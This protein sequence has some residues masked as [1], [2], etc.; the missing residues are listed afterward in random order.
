MSEIS[1]ESRL[2][3]PLWRNYN[4]TVSPNF[5]DHETGQ[6]GCA[7][8]IPAKGKA[9]LKSYPSGV[10]ADPSMFAT[11][12][13]TLYDGT[14]LVI[15]IGPCPGVY[16]ISIDYGGGYLNDYTVQ[17]N[18][19]PY[20]QLVKPCED[21][22]PDRLFILK[23]NGLLLVSGKVK[24]FFDNAPAGEPMTPVALDGTNSFETTS[25]GQ[26]KAVFVAANVRT[27]EAIW[28]QLLFL[29]TDFKL[30]VWGFYYDCFGLPEVTYGYHT[31]PQL[32]LEGVASFGQLWGGD[33][34]I[35]S[36]FSG[37]VY[38]LGYLD[39]LHSE[40]FPDG[41]YTTPQLLFTQRTPEDDLDYRQKRWSPNGDFKD[42]ISF[43]STYPTSPR[44]Y[45]NEYVKVRCF[46]NAVAIIDRFGDLYLSPCALAAQAW[47]SSS[48]LWWY[49]SNYNLVYYKNFSLAARDVADVYRTSGYT[50]YCTETD[51]KLYVAAGSKATN[52]DYGPY[53]ATFTNNYQ[54]KTF[55]YDS[56]ELIAGSK[57][58]S[59][60]HWTV[61]NSKYPKTTWVEIPTLDGCYKFPCGRGGMDEGL[62][63]AHCIGWLDRTGWPEYKGVNWFYYYLSK[64][65]AWDL[66]W[67]ALFPYQVGGV[68]DYSQWPIIAAGEK[69][70]AAEYVLTFP[71]YEVLISGYV[72][73]YE[74][75]FIGDYNLIHVWSAYNANYQ[76][77]CGLFVAGDVSYDITM[78]PPGHEG[79]SWFYNCVPLS[80]TS[81]LANNYL[82][83]Y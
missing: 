15:L 23:E 70:G 68:T 52:D 40:N 81:F 34:L 49:D 57:I 29:T 66:G 30:F 69:S 61:N 16:V 28:D 3:A 65:S 4:L 59:F 72:K 76:D 74:N 62:P 31:K 42:E 39:G 56:R 1:H 64:K 83:T 24:D 54:S 6:Y 26:S 53:H 45:V 75:I 18:D 80:V 51:R 67:E 21:T 10:A 19:S 32:L 22:S 2:G 17:M 9:R 8:A 50:Y 78:K 55:T 7:F 37:K 73:H 58:Q 77:Y 25:G 79:E 44:R 27:F 36:D 60:D 43:D 33:A 12:V 13:I 63:N 41:Q 35:W 11:Q 48:S 5:V 82:T 20:F 14:P 71:Y 46:S 47:P 38:G